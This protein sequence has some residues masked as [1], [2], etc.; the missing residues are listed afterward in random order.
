MI[1]MAEML[2]LRSDILHGGRLKV[3]KYVFSC[4]EMLG[5]L[6][7]SENWSVRVYQ[8]IYSGENAF[9]GFEL[10]V[11]RERSLRICASRS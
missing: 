3:K 6:A 11:K 5:M 10:R 8:I 2:P 7:S 1:D 9:L 4:Q